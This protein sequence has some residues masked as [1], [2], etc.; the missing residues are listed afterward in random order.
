MHRTA[1]PPAGSRLRCAAKAQSAWECERVEPAVVVEGLSKSFGSVKALDSLNLEVEQGEVLGFL[2]PNGAGK[3][4]TIRLL[5]GILFPSAG[6]AQV[7]GEP[8]GDTRTRGR[9]GFLPAD[10]DLDPRYT[11]REA[12]DFLGSLRGG[13]EPAEVATLLERFDLDPTRKI[14][15]LSTG[16]RRKVGVVQ[17]F[18]GHPELLILDEPTSGLDPLLQHELLDV[19]EERTEAGATVVL[20]SHALP[21]VERVAGRV[22]IL[23]RGTLALLS[24]IE[25]LRPKARQHLELHLAESVGAA[26][27]NQIP[28]VVDV[29]VHGSVVSVTVEGALGPLLR[30]LSRLDVQQI[31]SREADLEEVFLELY[32]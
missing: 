10:L 9:I 7:L 16:N 22:A 4:T 20:S 27:F 14:G 26:E 2:G 13:F 5:L 19:L 15:D 18:A 24:T 1:R 28:G 3:T 6:R 21:E 31:R 29:T 30:R 23:R 25:E 17:A 32:R 12:I 11:V 8:A